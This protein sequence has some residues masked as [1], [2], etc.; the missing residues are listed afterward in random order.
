MYSSRS[1]YNGKPS[2]KKGYGYYKKAYKT[3]ASEDTSVRVLAQRA[4][5]TAKSVARVLRKEHNEFRDGD[6]HTFIAV[7]P[8]V[9]LLNAV[10]SGTGESQHIG[11][12]FTMNDLKVRLDFSLAGSPEDSNWYRRARLIV[13]RRKTQE[14]PYSG[15]T[16]VGNQPLTW[17]RVLDSTERD[18]TAGGLVVTNWGSTDAD[19]CFY[20]RDFVPSAIQVLHDQLVKID[21]NNPQQQVE[22]N[23]KIP[24]TVRAM[25]QT[26]SQDIYWQNQIMMMII[27]LD[28][29]YSVAAGQLNVTWGSRITYHEA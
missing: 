3:R 2:F 15:M 11:K 24:Y 17:D 21:L 13:V 5:R 10:E 29:T 16:G 26:A 19:K 23:L 14:I 12:D 25:D 1:K 20:N 27:P 28:G 9:Q 4:L 6:N 7:D 18:P 8:Y 22:I